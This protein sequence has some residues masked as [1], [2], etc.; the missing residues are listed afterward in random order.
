MLSKPRLNSLPKP[1]FDILKRRGHK[2]EAIETMSAERIFSEYCEWHGYSHSGV[3]LY[4]LALALSQLPGRLSGEK[5]L[6]VPI[7][8]RAPFRPGRPSATAKA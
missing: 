2:D 7:A 5:L 4:E 8:R 1:V 3:T 6:G